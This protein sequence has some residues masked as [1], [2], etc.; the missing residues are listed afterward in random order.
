MLETGF[1]KIA[2][3]NEVQVGQTKK[4]EI[5]GKEILVANIGGIYYAIESKCPHMKG[6][7]SAGILEG[8]T[9]TCPNHHAKFDIITGKAVAHPKMGL[10]HPKVS[11]ARTYQIKVENQD[12]LIKR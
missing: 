7:L 1:I 5:E 11:D 4:I 9:V 12:I 6:D 10:F 2:T 8:N 3:T